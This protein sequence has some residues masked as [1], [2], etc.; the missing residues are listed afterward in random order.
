MNIHGFSWDHGVA[1]SHVL[2]QAINAPAPKIGTGTAVHLQHFSR[3][4]LALNTSKGQGKKTA[5]VRSVAVSL[6]AKSGF[7]VTL[8]KDFDIRLTQDSSHRQLLRSR[9][10]LMETKSSWPSSLERGLPLCRIFQVR[11]HGPIGSDL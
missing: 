1:G 9:D 3:D 7:E 8:P 5:S 11:R 10:S 6:W 2:H 4:V